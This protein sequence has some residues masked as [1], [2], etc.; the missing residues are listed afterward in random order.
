[1]SEVQQHRS[2]RF[3]VISFLSVVAYLILFPAFLINTCLPEHGDNIIPGSFSITGKQEESSTTQTDHKSVN[4]KSPPPITHSQIT[5]EQGAKGTYYPVREP[6]DAWWK[7]AVCDVNSSDYLLGLFTLFLVISTIGLWTQTE[8]LAAGAD[9]QSEKMVESIAAA[10][11]A[12]DAAVAT[13]RAWLRVEGVPTV[14]EDFTRD[15][16]TGNMRLVISFFVVNTGGSPAVNVRTYATTFADVLDVSGLKNRDPR[17]LVYSKQMRAEKVES[18]SA[19]FPGDKIHETYILTISR[20]DIDIAAAR[21]NDI[22]GRTK[23]FLPSVGIVID[24]VIPAEGTHRQT[25]QIFDL[26]AASKTVPGADVR[27]SYDRSIPARELRFKHGF[28]ATC[29][30]D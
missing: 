10:Q 17:N 23:T 8:R 27:I 18:G 1:M 6:K 30:A 15:D 5:I 13:N 16:A 19:L 4:P 2:R 28:V 25:A 29:F 20:G 11:K 22:E 24:Y 3:W 14:A 9:D 26:L 7:G 12:A 21:H